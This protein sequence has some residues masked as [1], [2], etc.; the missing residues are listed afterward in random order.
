MALGILIGIGVTIFLV[1]TFS[2]MDWNH[3]TII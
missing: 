1:K 2:N 3:R